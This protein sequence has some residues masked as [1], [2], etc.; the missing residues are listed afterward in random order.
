MIRWSYAINQFKP[1]FDDFTRRRDHLRALRIISIS[2]FRGVELSSGTGRWEALGNPTQVAANFGS[3]AGFAQVVRECDLDAVSSWYWDPFQ[4]HQE[5]LSGPTD[6]ADAAARELLVAHARWYAAALAELGGSVLV[7]RPAASAWATGELPGAALD[8]I[9]AS[10]NAVG[11]AIGEYGIRLGLHMD[12]LS[13][14]RLGGGLDALLS[15][16]D[17]RR[18]G[19]CVDTAEFAVAG[20]D[21]V[22]VIRTHRDRV[23]HVHLKNAAARD[24]DDEFLIRNAEQHLRRAGGRRRIER[25][26]LE[27]G[28]QPQ[29][30]DASAAVRALREIDY[31]GWIVVESDFSPHPPTS[32]MLN[33]WELQHVLAPLGDSSAERTTSR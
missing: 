17:P 14:L 30:V 11:D 18:V 32:T 2:G 4:P 26:F 19:L 1:Q 9:A 24:E 7:A 13:A 22:D 28:T 29:L 5:D 21:P 20:I 8:T 3:V 10:W 15:R 31:D 33:G 27:L 6:P 12:F 16:T 23:V 25:W